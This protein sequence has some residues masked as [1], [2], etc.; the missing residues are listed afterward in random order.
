MGFSIPAEEYQRFRT[1]I[2][3]ESGIALGDQKQ[4]LVVS[5]LSKR[6]SELGLMTFPEYYE[7]VVSDSSRE[8]FT[9]MLD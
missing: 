5:R 8:E 7:Q 1:L 9:R 3:N 6:L 2:Y 4:A